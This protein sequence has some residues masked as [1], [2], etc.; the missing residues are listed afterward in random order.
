[1]S[2][3]IYKMTPAQWQGMVNEEAQYVSSKTVKNAWLFVSSVLVFAGLPRISL[4][5]PQLVAH[6]TPFLPPDEIIRFV[7]YIKGSDIEIVCLL[8]LSSLRAS[9]AHALHWEDIDLD[10]RVIH[11]HRSIVRDEHNFWIEKETNKNTSSTR[12]VPIMMDNLY[13]ALITSYKDSG[14]VVSLSMPQVKKRLDKACIGAEV[15]P[16]T[17]HGLRHSFASLAAHLGMPEAIAMQIG[18][19]SNDKIMK[20]IYTHV[21][22]TDVNRYQNEMSQYYNLAQ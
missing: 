3:D 14:H 1:M 15:T 11:V 10:N 22:E 19:W 20:R 13:E 12:I 2:K 16:V 21:L 7:N 9:E 5:L 18:G 8:G 4:S 6:E 17:F